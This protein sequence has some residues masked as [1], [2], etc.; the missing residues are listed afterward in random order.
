MGGGSVSPF[1]WILPPVA[2]GH[3]M[4]NSASQQI[5]GNRAKLDRKSVV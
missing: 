3:Q 4:V 2:I 5:S 1:E